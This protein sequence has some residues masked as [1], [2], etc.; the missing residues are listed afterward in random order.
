[1][2]EVCEYVA[3]CKFYSATAFNC[4]HPAQDRLFCGAYKS[5]EL[6]VATSQFN[7]NNQSQQNK[8]G[9]DKSLYEGTEKTGSADTLSLERDESERDYLT[10]KF[11]DITRP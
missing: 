7:K 8:I 6:N 3:V 11:E 2:N 9:A 5:L 1:M 10:N 4:T